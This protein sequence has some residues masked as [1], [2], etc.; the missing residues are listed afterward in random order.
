MSMFRRPGEDSSS[1]SEA[2]YDETDNDDTGASHQDSVLSRIQTLDSAASTQSGQRPTLPSLEMRQNSTQNVRDLMLHA[3]LE[4]KA[5]AAAAQKLGKDVS[6]PDV[7]RMGREAYQEI[8]RQI[9]NNVDDTYAGEEMRNHRATAQEGISKL[10]RNNLSRLVAVPEG[11]AFSQALASRARNG[12][13]MDLPRQPS[14]GFDI[15]SGIHA[16]TELQLR[17]YPGLQTDRYAREF[18]ELGIVGKGGYGKVFKAKHKLDGSF[19]AVKRI[20]VS[21][22]KLAKIQHHGSEELENMLQEVRSLARF[23]HTNVVRYHNAWLEF[24]TAPIDETIVPT[25]TLLREDRLLEN[26]AVTSAELP[27]RD[28]L[29][30]NI[31]DLFLSD[32]FER[33]NDSYGDGIVFETSDTGAHADSAKSEAE[34]MSYKA[35]LRK[36]SR[37]KARR[38]SQASQATIATI[39]STKSRMSAVEDVDEEEEEEDV[40]MIPRSHMHYTSEVTESMVTQSDA[41]D[42]LIP[43]RHVG[44]MLTLNVQMSLCETNLAA[45]L[46]ADRSNTDSLPIGRHCFHPCLSL[47][48]FLNIISGV[49]YL[50][51]QGVVHRDLKP[52]NVFLSL[53]SARHPPYGSVDLSTCKVCPKRGCLHITP[54]IG[55]FGLVAALDD[56]CLDIGA[57]SKPVGTEFYRPD[58]SLRI[59]EKLDVFAL[60]VMGFEMLEAFGTRMERAAALADLRRGKFPDDFSRKI[61]N[62]GDEVQSLLSSMLHAD[63]QQR[64]GC[65]DARREIGNVVQSLKA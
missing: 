30:T 38:G 24:T 65:E 10:T 35:Q 21:P 3:L 12:L 26:V 57:I 7:Q 44:P 32:P 5:L 62:V 37:R 55:D 13:S 60:G 47:E 11:A 34:H 4:E 61:E 27:S 8:A 23:D 9:S 41:P 52:A 64:L 1:T 53:S 31:D 48:L 25:S 36:S 6:D 54:R 29:H 59:N 50:H 20:P 19:Y 40:E 49:E 39:S 63:E 22:A 51:A 17:G 46:S 14:T 42:R 16:P 58:T 18:S 28:E 15:L 33:A 56:S 43:L 2:S 45:F